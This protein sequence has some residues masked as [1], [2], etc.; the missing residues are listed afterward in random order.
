MM[1][2]HVFNGT[3][4]LEKVKK[5]Q[6]YF[7]LN[8]RAMEKNQFKGILHGEKKGNIFTITEITG[9]DNVKRGLRQKLRT[10]LPKNIKINKL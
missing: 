4:Q 8:I 6:N 9:Q 10:I 7:L 2:Y 3:K 1:R 5:Q